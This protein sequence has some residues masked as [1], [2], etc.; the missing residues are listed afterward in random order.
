[1]WREGGGD[2]ALWSLWGLLELPS[3]GLRGAQLESMA[4]QQS[5]CPARPGTGFLE[6]GLS[7]KVAYWLFSLSHM[8]QLKKSG[9]VSPHS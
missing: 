7:P 6:M 3:A 8:T 4:F 1:M 2:K 5:S 9:N